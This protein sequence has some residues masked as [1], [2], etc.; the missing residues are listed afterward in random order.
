M[1]V[2]NALIAV[3]SQLIYTGNLREYWDQNAELHHSTQLTRDEEMITWTLRQMRGLASCLKV[4][5]EKNCRHGDLKPENI[6][7][8]RDTGKFGRLVIADVGLSKIHISVTEK[9]KQSTS[10]SFATRRYA[11]PEIFME[12]RHEAMSRDYDIWS[13]GVILLE[14]L[15]WLLYGNKK[16]QAPRTLEKFWSPG[17]EGI[18]IDPRA[19]GWINEINAHLKSESAFRDIIKL[20]EDLLLKIE[21][22]SKQKEYSTSRAN[23]VWLSDSL[24][25]IYKRAQEDLSYKYD[26]KVWQQAKSS[27]GTTPLLEVPIRP[28]VPKLLSSNSLGE[29]TTDLA[30]GH[31]SLAITI[32]YSES[33]TYLQKKPPI[34]VPDEYNEVRKR[35]SKTVLS[36]FNTV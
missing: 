9:R 19:Q 1:E 31:G 11:A 8:Y 20:V 34:A 18:E 35:S 12:D 29:E 24:E 13:V 2:C 28:P 17:Q 7:W 25:K 23:A 14:W 27:T 4:L 21:L 22:A 3:Y 16:L 15:L 6:L 26:P 32:N 33:R 5:W 10:A 36:F 30:T